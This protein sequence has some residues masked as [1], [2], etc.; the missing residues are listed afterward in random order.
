MHRL[1]VG[2]SLLGLFSILAVGCSSGNPDTASEETGGG[3]GTETAGDTTGGETEGAES[4]SSA[5]AGAAIELNAENTTIAFKGVHTDKEKPDPHDG[6]FNSLS[7]KVTMSGES[8]AGIEVEIQVESMTTDSE[9][10]TAHLKSPDFFNVK[11]NPTATFKT[12]EIKVA[13]GATTVTGDLTMLGKTQ[14][15][16]FPAE[17]SAEAGK[18]KLN[19]SFDVDR[20]AFGMDYGVDNIEKN[21]AMTIS[22]DA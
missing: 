5:D 13:D 16:T 1:F 18:V 4:D 10:L 11:E 12:T 3:A 7:G 8:V 15:I 9:K 2:L 19:A 21:V 14:S 22:I 6:K 20:T 17:L